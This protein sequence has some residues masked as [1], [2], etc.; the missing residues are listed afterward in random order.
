MS[1]ISVRRKSL[2]AVV[3]RGSSGQFIAVCLEHDIVSQG[4]TREGAIT[5]LENDYRAYVRVAEARGEQ[6]FERSKAAPG[7]FWSKFES[8]APIQGASST[9][10]Q[11]RA[12]E[13]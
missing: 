2:S 9:F 7:E 12:V 4:D 13:S 11:V 5:A 10:E 1:V 6:P 8:A 3:F